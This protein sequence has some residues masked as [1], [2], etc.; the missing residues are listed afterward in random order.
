MNR[1]DWLAISVMAALLGAGCGEVKVAPPAYDVLFGDTAQD[2]NLPT[3]SSATDAGADSSVQAD[4]S[5]DSGQVVDAGAADGAGIDGAL[6][7]ADPADAGQPDLP[8]QCV[9]A[10]DCVDKVGPLGPCQVAICGA[11]ECDKANAQEGKFCGFECG[12]SGGNVSYRKATCSAGT[13]KPAG[14]PVACVPDFSCLLPQCSLDSG[15]IYV[16]QDSKCSGSN[17]CSSA[18]CVADKGCV[19][20]PLDGVCD[21][22]D[23]CTQ[24]DKCLGGTCKGGGNKC[25]CAA[26]GSCKTVNPC[27]PATCGPGNICVNQVSVGAPCDDQDACTTNDK[28]DGTGGCGGDATNCDDKIACTKDSCE[29]SQGCVHGPD[30]ALCDDGNPCTEGTCSIKGCS[31]VIKDA[32]ACDDGDA[33]T[34]GDKCAGTVCAGQ[35]A[36]PCAD[37]GP[38]K[39]ASCDPLTGQCPWVALAEGQPCD[40]GNACTKIDVCGDGVCGDGK[41]PCDDGKPCTVDACDPTNG[42]IHE[43]NESGP[44]SDGDPCTKGD[45]CVAGACKA[46]PAAAC[47]DGNPCTQDTCDK[48]GACNFPAITGG[49]PCAQNSKMCQQGKCAAVFPPKGMAWVPASTF[50]MG[51]NGK[52]D[53]K[54]LSHEEP[55]HAV[56]L[57]SYFVDIKEITAGAYKICVLATKCTPAKAGLK[58]GT[59]NTVK[60]TYPINYVTWQ[61]AAQFCAAQG[62]RLCTEAE[63]EFA[64]R[65]L[66]GRRYPWGN[67]SPTCALA[68]AGCGTGPLATGSKPGGASPF[69]L[70]DMAGNVREWTADWYSA[71]FY[72]SGGGK[73]ML[74]PKG[75]AK[76]ASRVVRGG[77][78]ASSSAQLRTS[79]RAFI[80]PTLTSATVGFR[81]C[82][83]IVK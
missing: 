70:L 63:W 50:Q 62:S 58:E 13:C 12:D 6:T 57:S 26:D 64:A 73:V 21:D 66:D 49:K 59:Y 16:A 18:V 9:I 5:G 61:Q 27:L 14:E 33:C 41:P 40:D 79:D 46:G 69:G 42:C 76:G 30:S 43:L 75:P 80:T 38:C 83:S 74:N 1:I 37:P 2:A 3:D 78:Y 77:Y 67:N 48:S 24:G 11:G 54:C 60:S 56:T 35:P 51:C 20:T 15:C 23:N 32:Q 72:S 36:P 55:A 7:D 10:A 8:P 52:V 68:V 19:W 29:P 28:C 65:G 53:N 47:D 4:A 39:A 31:S 45:V 34:V 81:C 71:S 44:C 17:P 25:A 82:R 22:G